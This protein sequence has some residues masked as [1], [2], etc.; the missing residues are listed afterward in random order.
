MIVTEL[1]VNYMLLLDYA[2]ELIS[3]A[4]YFITHPEERPVILQAPPKLASQYE[5]P[6]KDT[7]PL[8]SHYSN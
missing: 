2:E 8:F 1:L 6:D 7:V 5:L 3:K 4:V